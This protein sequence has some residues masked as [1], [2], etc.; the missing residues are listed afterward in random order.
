MQ[1]IKNPQPAM[2]TQQIMRWGHDFLRIRGGIFKPLGQWGKS[3][4]Q[5]ENSSNCQLPFLSYSPNHLLMPKTS[6]V[7]IAW[8]GQ[9][10]T[11]QIRIGE[12]ISFGRRVLTPW[13]SKNPKTSSHSN[14]HTRFH[15][16]LTILL[17]VRLLEASG[18]SCVCIHSH[19][20]LFT[21]FSSGWE[22][23]FLIISGWVSSPMTLLHFP[24]VFQARNRFFVV[25]S[26]GRR[27][28]RVLGVVESVLA[29]LGP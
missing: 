8:D 7:D 9:G 22:I 6:W 2:S 3:K 5:R 17:H 20:W 26:S 23:I 14:M 16:F 12:A 11:V 27:D 10:M 24:I 13:A 4:C 21:S 19:F 15:V 25:P 29:T 18:T 1:L 28:P